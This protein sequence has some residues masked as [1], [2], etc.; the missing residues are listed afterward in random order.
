V[1]PEGPGPFVPCYPELVPGVIIISRDWQSR[2][3]LRAQLIEE[4]VDVRAFISPKEV[5]AWVVPGTVEGPEAKGS[6]ELKACG[7]SRVE[8]RRSNSRSR[9]FSPALVLA[10]LSLIPDRAEVEELAALLGRLPPGVALW[11][12]A[13]R[14][15]R[16]GGWIRDLKGPCPEEVLFRPIDV[17]ALVERI[18]LRLTVRS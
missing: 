12:V 13:S 8:G 4:G 1:H 10:D 15:D 18:K 7:E 9:V 2:A 14:S 11:I 5:A 6:G 3:L 17:G 16:N